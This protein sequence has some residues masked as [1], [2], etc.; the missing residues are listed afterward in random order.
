MDFDF[1]PLKD[2]INIEKHQLSLGDFSGFD[3]DM[4]AQVDDRRDY[5]ETRV[6]GYGRI[7][8]RPY[9]IVFT[10]RGNATRLISFRRMR[11]KEMRRYE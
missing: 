9:C 5:G 6:R 7:A 2:A 3:A 1:D 10:K 11:E 4:I 8:G